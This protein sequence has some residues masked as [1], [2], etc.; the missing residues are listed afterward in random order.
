MGGNDI[1]RVSTLLLRYC[2][3]QTTNYI[4][5]LAEIYNKPTQFLQKKYG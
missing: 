2:N 5:K 1:E 3:T 4:K